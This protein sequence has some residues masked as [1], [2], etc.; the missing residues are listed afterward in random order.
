VHYFAEE[1]LFRLGFRVSTDHG[2]YFFAVFP[3]AKL[4]TVDVVK[5][6]AQVLLHS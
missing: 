1:H 6:L 5:A 3:F 4:N 2:Y